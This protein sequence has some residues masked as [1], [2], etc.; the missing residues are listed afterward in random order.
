MEIFMHDALGQVK[1]LLE[2]ERAEDYKGTGKRVALVK[3]FMKPDEGKWG[4]RFEGYVHKTW[5]SGT[6]KPE[7]YLLWGNTDD[8]NQRGITH[9]KTP[10][11]RAVS[12]RSA[13]K[14][15]Y[16]AHKAM[17]F[18]TFKTIHD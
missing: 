1:V 5:R 18:V 11:G 8:L 2:I 4:D 16:E 10:S 3:C 17:E 15:L 12:E 6:L 7:Y 13:L 9:I 14:R